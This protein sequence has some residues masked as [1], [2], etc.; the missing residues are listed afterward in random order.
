MLQ[1]AFELETREG[2]VR[3]GVSPAQS[4][5]LEADGSVIATLAGIG[6]RAAERAILA[7]WDS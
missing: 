1:G 3:V 7:E 4:E 5:F 2:E 6:M